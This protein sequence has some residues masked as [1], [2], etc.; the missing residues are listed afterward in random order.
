MEQNLLN[1]LELP[2]RPKRIARRALLVK[3]S[4]P[5]FLL[6]IYKNILLNDNNKLIIGQYEDTEKF[7]LNGHDINIIDQSD[8]IMTFGAHNPHSGNASKT[9]RGKRIWFDVSEVP[10]GE[11]II[12]AELR[13]FQSLEKGFEYNRTYTIALY[14][15]ARTN[16][17]G[18]MKHYIN[19]A[20][21]TT[22]KEGWIILNI[23]RALE[24][25]VKHPK[26]NR[27]LFL[28][29]HHADYTGHILRPDDIGVVGVSGIPDKQP[30]MVGFFKSP[31]NRGKREILRRR[32]RDRPKKFDFSSM[33]VQN[34]P[35]TSRGV[36]K[37]INPCNMKTLY[38]SFKDLQ[39]QDWIIAPE[40]YD[41]FYCSGECNFPLNIHMNATNHAIVQTLVHLMKP[42][43]IP[44]PC[45]A[46]TKLSPISVLY[47][48]DDSN[49]VLKK[50]K[51]MVIN[52]CGCH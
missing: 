47:F 12:A 11:H 2:E 23:S 52:S 34:N 45:C 37:K 19:S 7:N 46:P 51:N 5:K 49:V 14:R 13:L 44:K 6:N 9:N 48:L 10:Y 20:N 50:Y 18:R 27:G 25:W 4:A 31:D 39:W 40:G 16:N 29:V 36:Y 8:F 17:G 28:A 15:V 43:E 1:I 42:K 32:K 38:I 22:G 26:E 21:T 30:F 33:N 24:Y 35:Y 3:R 41:A